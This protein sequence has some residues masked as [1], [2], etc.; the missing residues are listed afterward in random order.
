M[1]I[2]K[3]NSFWL[4]S[5][6]AIL[7]SV[8]GLY[9]SGLLHSFT[10]CFATGFKS[11][12]PDFSSTSLIISAVLAWNIRMLAKPGILN[13]INVLLRTS[14]NYSAS[15]LLQMT[16]LSPLFS[17]YISYSLVDVQTWFV[18][19]FMV[20]T[21]KSKVFWLFLSLLV[22]TATF[23]IADEVIS[24]VFMI[25]HQLHAGHLWQIICTIWHLLTFCLLIWHTPPG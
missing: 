16:S 20:C 11:K 18:S 13:T 1:S 5:A 19:D 8:S 4:Q 6:I 22:F 2:R 25:A 23:A 12:S 24:I 14:D 10:I 15:F 7:E 17:T 9:V 3:S 21:T